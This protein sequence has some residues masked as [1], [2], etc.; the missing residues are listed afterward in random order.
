MSM[1]HLILFIAFSFC[2]AILYPQESVSRELKD[3]SGRWKFAIDDSTNRNESFQHS[4]WLKPLTDSSNAIIDM[5]V[6]AS[7]NDIT[8]D[9]KFRDFI[10]WSW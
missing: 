5:P 4:W 7:Y 9:K 2:E 8:Q 6:P 3:L 1:I 10:G